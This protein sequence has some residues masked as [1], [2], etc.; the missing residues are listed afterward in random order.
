M[1]GV[2][3]ESVQQEIQK[4]LIDAIRNRTAVDVPGTILDLIEQYPSAGVQAE[5]F[6]DFLIHRAIAIGVPIKI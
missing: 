2:I 6:R 4:H 5:E 1:P 3:A